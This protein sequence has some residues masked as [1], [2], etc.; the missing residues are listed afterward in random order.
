MISTK[1]VNV[2]IF[3]NGIEALNVRLNYKQTL[4]FDTKDREGLEKGRVLAKKILSDHDLGF[5]C[6]VSFSS[7]EESCAFLFDKQTQ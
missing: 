6:V 5:P 3:D 7:K 2:I 4:T 1:K